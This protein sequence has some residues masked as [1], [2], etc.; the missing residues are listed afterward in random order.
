M[1]KQS[2]ALQ[3]TGD[4]F[5]PAECNNFIP[6]S[7]DPDIH[8][9]F[10]QGSQGYYGQTSDLNPVFGFKEDIS[11]PYGGIPGWARICFAIIATGQ[12]IN[13]SDWVHGYEAILLPGGR[14][15]MG[16]WLDL[17][18]PSGRG[19]FIFWDVEVPFYL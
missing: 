3:M 10:F 14:I 6:M 11:F 1:G 7:E 17:N 15:M 18:E 12:D 9:V 2:L 4:E 13:S 19:P 16:R 5:W 8:R